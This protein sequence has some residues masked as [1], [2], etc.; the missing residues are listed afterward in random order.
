MKLT[1]APKLLLVDDEPV[2][3]DTLAIV[4]RQHGYD[5]TVAYH[6]AEAIEK[7]RQLRPEFI[8]MGVVMPGMYG[9]EAG[10]IILDEQPE[11]R[12]FFFS[13]WKESVRLFEDMEKRGYTFGI[14]PKPL[15]PQDLLKKLGELGFEPSIMPPSS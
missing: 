3:V 1:H 7:A 9:T 13:G 6:G 15:H 4:L 5:C 10:R 11:C 12:M 2:I 14:M 8:L